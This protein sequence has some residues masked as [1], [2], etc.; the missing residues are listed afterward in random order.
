VFR[1]A[2]G[3]WWLAHDHTSTLPGDQLA[4]LPAPADSVAGPRGPVRLIA[5][6]PVPLS[7]M[8]RGGLSGTRL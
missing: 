2:H 5:S 1:R 8:R 6:P 3:R 7:A 4:A